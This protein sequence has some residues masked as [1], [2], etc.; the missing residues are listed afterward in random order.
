MT[1]FAIVAL[2][3]DSQFSASFTAADAGDG[4]FT[5]LSG[6]RWSSASGAGRGSI[7]A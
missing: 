3:A 5:G 1:Q 6:E 4:R 2:A 7:A